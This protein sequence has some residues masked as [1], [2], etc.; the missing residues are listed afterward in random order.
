MN[1]VD[2][3]N[4]KYYGKDGYGFDMCQ[5]AFLHPDIAKSAISDMSKK[6]DQCRSNM[7]AAKT[8]FEKKSN[9]MTKLYSDIL[10]SFINYD[11]RLILLV[12]VL[13]GK[14]SIN[15]QLSTDI[16]EEL[17]RCTAVMNRSDA[18]IKFVF[19]NLSEEEQDAVIQSVTTGE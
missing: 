11:Q 5:Y 18:L 2:C 12:D 19:S 13:A 14:A 1:L 9:E 4:C 3:Y 10:K 6:L 15:V 8:Q 16:K 7:W 17:Q